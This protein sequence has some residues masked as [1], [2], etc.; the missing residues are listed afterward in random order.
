[1]ASTIGFLPHPFSTATVPNAPPDR[2]QRD[3][4][5]DLFRVPNRESVDGRRQSGTARFSGDL[6]FFDTP[7]TVL[8]SGPGFW[9]SPGTLTNIDPVNH[10]LQGD[11]GHGTIQFIATYGSISFTSPIW[12]GFTVGAIPEPSTHVMLLAGLSLLGFWARS[13]K[14]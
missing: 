3:G 11:E 9:G 6:Q 12:H 2:G 7:F 13:R 8:S 1:V 10:V 14:R 5:H 4:Q